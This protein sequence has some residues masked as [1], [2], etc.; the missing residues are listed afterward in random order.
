MSHKLFFI[1]FFCS[2][3]VLLAIY[4]G[5]QLRFPDEV[6]YHQLGVSIASGNGFSLDS[7]AP[8]ALRPPGYPFALSLL[9]RFYPQPIS[10]KLF[11]ALIFIL[12]AGLISKMSG[13]LISYLFLLAYPVLLFTTTTLYPVVL[14][15]FLLLPIVQLLINSEHRTRSILF[16]GITLGILILNIPS[17]MLTAP[18][19]AWILFSHESGKLQSRIGKVTLLTLSTLLIVAPWTYRN[20]KAFDAFIP[21]S[22]NSGL[23]LY[24]GNSPNAGPNTGV[25]VERSE[26]LETVQDFNEVDTDRYYRHQALDWIK[27]NPLAALKL[28]TAK[29]LNYFNFRN[30]L[31]TAS[32]SSAL[33][34]LM[35]FVTWY[36]LLGLFVA[37]LFFIHKFPLSPLEKAIYLL[38]ISNVFLSAIFFTRIRFRLPFDQLMILANAI[39]VGQ[40]LPNCR[41]FPFKPLTKPKIAL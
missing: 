12:S 19:L 34:D 6:E 29:S 28:Y 40:L 5:N 4:N 30:K 9:Y 32:Q 25:N 18:V 41:F 11:N 36:P 14:S 20:Y 31:K 24:L 2:I 37:R 8:T 23:N 39:F 1:C 38:V 16:A 13:T 17:F 7:G 27:S 21:V 3:P 35:M 26:I 33:K 15:G 10:A 22:A